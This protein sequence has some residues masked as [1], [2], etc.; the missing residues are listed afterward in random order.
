[1]TQEGTTF[2]FKL[3]K[4]WM[5]ATTPQVQ[6]SLVLKNVSFIFLN[7]LHNFLPILLYSAANVVSNLLILPLGYSPASWF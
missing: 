3:C 7:G 5:S 4:R 1:M 6:L 2:G